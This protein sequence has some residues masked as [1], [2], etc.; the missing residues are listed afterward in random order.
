MTEL[1]I[2]C[3]NLRNLINR[4]EEAIAFKLPLNKVEDVEKAI[5]FSEAFLN[6]L[7]GHVELK[8]EV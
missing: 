1:V 6:S 7:E 8:Q 3:A 5:S 4:I 2:A